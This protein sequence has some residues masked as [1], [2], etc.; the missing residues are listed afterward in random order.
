MKKIRI[1]DLIYE[2]IIR[3]EIKMC[4]Y[5]ES[6][7]NKINKNNINVVGCYNTSNIGDLAFKYVLM[8][9]SKKNNIKINFYSFNEIYNI[10][11]NHLTIVGGGGVLTSRNDCPLLQL[12]NIFKKNPKNI[13][14]LGVSGLTNHDKWSDDVE[15]IISNLGFVSLRSKY[16]YNMFKS[17]FKEVESLYHPDLVFSLPID[18]HLYSRKN[19]DK[20]KVIGF[21]ATP[22]LMKTVNG[23]FENNTEVSTWYADNFPE[24]SKLRNEICNN[25]ISLLQQTAEY[26]IQQG[27]EVFHVSFAL[28]D[29]LF[30]KSI[31]YDKKVKVLPYER[32]PLKVT[33][34][35][36]QFDKF[37]ATRFHS[38]VFCLKLGIPVIPICYANKCNYII[39]DFNL[40]LDDS[41]NL[42][43]LG[44]NK[45][46]CLDKIINNNGYVVEN[47][48]LIKQ[49]KDSELAIDRVFSDLVHNV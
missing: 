25:Y 27:W 45:K 29:W 11:P 6:Q 22:F 44:K 12:F 48:L 19:A 18:K 13:I 35:I 7:C 41:I 33:P 34:Q 42:V 37:V 1:A 32:N 30:A 43:E 28:E 3:F 24:E 2:K 31:F 4:S 17:Y 16:D 47:N 38:L 14:L 9:F 40:D 39:S 10:N 23:S 8:N 21:N 46:K 15:K 36:I 49:I 5:F 20:R 26:Y